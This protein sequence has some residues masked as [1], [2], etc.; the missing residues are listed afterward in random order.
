MT[1]RLVLVAAVALIDDDKRVLIAQRP[2]NKPMAGFWE[3]PGGKIEPGETPIQ[4]AERELLEETGLQAESLT[5]LMRHEAAERMHYVFE[6]EFSD[7]PHPKALHEIADCR[8][9]HPDQVPM[10]KDE[11]KL[12]IRSLLACD[13]AMAAS[14]R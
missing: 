5:L 9:A 3:F 14:V 11:I 13:R 8:F 10:L 6:A 12:L 7:A 1:K 4:A 2:A